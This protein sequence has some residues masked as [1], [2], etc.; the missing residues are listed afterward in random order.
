MMINY[1]STGVED[2][3]HRIGQTGWAGATGQAHT[4]FSE[5]DGKYAKELIK[6][7]EGDG[8]KVP[9]ELRNIARCSGGMYKG[10]GM[11]SQWGNGDSG[12][13]SVSGRSSYGG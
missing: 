3:V 10:R 6:M 7:L 13:C 11:V 12:D 4:F 5:Q 2:Y 9:A 1:D 8:Q